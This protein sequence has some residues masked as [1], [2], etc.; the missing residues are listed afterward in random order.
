MSGALEALLWTVL[1]WFGLSATACGFWAAL[2]TAALEA[3]PDG[4]LHT[5]EQSLAE[6]IRVT[7]AAAETAIWIDRFGAAG[8]RALTGFPPAPSPQALAIL[9]RAQADVAEGWRRAASHAA[10]LP[11][12]AGSVRDTTIAASTLGRLVEDVVGSLATSARES[13]AP[14]Q[15]PPLARSEEA[16]ASTV[17]IADLTAAQAAAVTAHVEVRHLLLRTTIWSLVALS[18]AAVAVTL[19]GS[20]IVVLCRLAPP[21]PPPTSLPRPPR[22]RGASA[23]PPPSKA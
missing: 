7:T 20:T 1:G 16:P 19:V 15:V 17:V 23:A 13:F 5:A 2:N 4:V 6:Q 22:R 8:L 18:G 11:H 3:D 12:Q 21:V 9:G 14:A 10:T